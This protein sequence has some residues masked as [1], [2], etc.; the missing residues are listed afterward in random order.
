MAA[1]LTG[2]KIEAHRKVRFRDLSVTDVHQKSELLQAV[3]K[4]LTHGMLVLG[5][6]VERFERK[7]AEYC[8]THYCVGIGSGSDAI[9]LALRSYDIGL[10]DEV[11]T[12]PLSWI[13]TLNAIHLCGARPVF[14]DICEDLNIDADLIEAA[15]TPSTRAIVPVHFT[16]RLCDMEKICSVAKN[17]LAQ[18]TSSRLTSSSNR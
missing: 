5:P 11:I 14:V 1:N 18:P 15:I 13:A 7:I 9:Y 4:V 10:G 2:Q 8:G 17:P 12:T 16:G 6:E 3:D